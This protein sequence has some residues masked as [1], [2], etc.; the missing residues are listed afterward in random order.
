MCRFY[1]GL[2]LKE[3]PI[4]LISEES[5][6]LSSVQLQSSPSSATSSSPVNEIEPTKKRARIQVIH[7]DDDDDVDMISPIKS[8][9]SSSGENAL[10]SHEDHQFKQSNNSYIYC[11]EAHHLS[12]NNEDEEENKSKEFELPIIS[13]LLPSVSLN[14]ILP[15]INNHIENPE[16]TLL[17]VSCQILNINVYPFYPDVSSGRLPPIAIGSL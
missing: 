16:Q 1:K 9:S 17:E 5:S 7:E 8:S 10:S 15:E 11:P 4:S 14:G 6:A 13:L 2:T 3:Q 12:S